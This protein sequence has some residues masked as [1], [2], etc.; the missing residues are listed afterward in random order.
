ML[1]L[2]KKVVTSYMNGPQ[3]SLSR[4][5]VH[6][7]R[8]THE[9]AV[10]AAGIHGSKGALI[11]DNYREFELCLLSQ[12]SSNEEQHA[13]VDKLFRRQLAVPLIGNFRFTQ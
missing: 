13:R 8:A 1:Q 4:E 2:V 12:D 3:V 10:V 9:K 6:N 5:G 7:I 11:W